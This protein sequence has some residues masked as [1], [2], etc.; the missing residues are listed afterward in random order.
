MDMN[1]LSLVFF[2][3]I[4]LFFILFF[5]TPPQYRYIVIFVASYIFYGYANWK[6]LFILAF[7]TAITY[8]GGRFLEKTKD[9]KILILSFSAN[10]AILL[11][12]KY[13]NFAIGSIN[14]IRS[15]FSGQEHLFSELDII[16][17]IGLSFVIFQSCT[18][19]TDIY[20]GNIQA[21][22]NII[23]YGAFV[24]FFPTILSG[25]IQKS[26]TLLP[27]IQN[28][29]NFEFEEAKKG[30]L[31]FVWGMF[32]KLLVA[33]KL[34]T[35]VN[36][37]FSDWQSYN[38]AYCI[39]AA[40]SFS[41][42]IYSDFSA[43]SDMAR[44]IAKIMGI[45][46]DINFKNPYLSLTTSEFWNRWHMSLNSWFMENL[47]I[48]LGGNRKGAVRKYINI[49]IV[50][51]VSGL[52]HGANWHCVIWGVLNGMLVIIGKIT[53][54]SREK[55][56][57]KFNISEEVESIIFIKRMITFGLITLTWVFFRNKTIEALHIVQKIIF[58][59]PLNFFDS[60]LLV[61]SGTSAATFMTIIVT[62]LFCIVQV[63]RKN[64]HTF[65][66]TYCKQ[67][68]LI[69]YFVLAFIINMCVFAA[70]STTLDINTQFIYFQF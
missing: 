9:K 17:P 41:L 38:S 63:K 6:M 20:R 32:E 58:F 30:T 37:V 8:W 66:L 43:Y 61:I 54:K 28:P 35:I 60:N 26:R 11:F 22:K 29:R 59:N 57:A 3:F 18:Y 46:V 69:Q 55:I 48:P 19:L 53:K 7:I 1:F 21:E 51:L 39:I 49:F 47:Y 62:V 13:T 50:F 68:I 25:P 44:G 40:I 36:R 52:W 56:Y 2:I 5:R 64:E 27:Q 15:H 45:Q 31:L 23:R 16:L 14:S 42:Y 24:A 12:F 10:V 4:I 70:C 34:E 65:Y 67:P 33:N